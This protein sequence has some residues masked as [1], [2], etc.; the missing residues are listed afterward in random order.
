[1]NLYGG[2]LSEIIGM[3]NAVSRDPETNWHSMNGQLVKQTNIVGITLRMRKV[4]DIGSM[5]PRQVSITG[6]GWMISLMVNKKRPTKLAKDAPG[7]FVEL[8][9]SP[10]VKV[11]AFVHSASVISPEAFRNEMTVLRTFEAMW[12]RG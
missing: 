3:M 4:L 1:M 7:E 10:D 6:K 12:N 2:K 8:L 5:F 11:K 9:V